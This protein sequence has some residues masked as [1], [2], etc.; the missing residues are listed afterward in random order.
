[1]HYGYEFSLLISLSHGCLYDITLFFLQKWYKLPEDGS[2][3]LNA[4]Y[5][6]EY[7]VNDVIVD[8]MYYA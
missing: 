4:R 3:D 8:A 2:Y 6:F 5:V 7:N 1:M